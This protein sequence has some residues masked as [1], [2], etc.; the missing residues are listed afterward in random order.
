M[1]L[2]NAAVTTLLEACRKHRN[3]P[4]FVPATVEMARTWRTKDFRCLCYGTDIGL[5]QAASGNV[6]REL[7][8]D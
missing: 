2:A 7:R 3:A 6:P 5:F 4:G 1:A 8:S